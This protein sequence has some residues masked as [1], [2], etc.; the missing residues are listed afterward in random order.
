[1]KARVSA[2]LVISARQ[3]P[4]STRDAS[5]SRNGEGSCDHQKVAMTL[6]DTGNAPGTE[7]GLIAC[8]HIRNVGS[9]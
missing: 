9:M 7:G 6:R 8:G 2:L 3:G 5:D 4:C 1:M